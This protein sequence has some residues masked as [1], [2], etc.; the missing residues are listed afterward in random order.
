MHGALHPML[1]SWMPLSHP[2]PRCTFPCAPLPSRRPLSYFPPFPLYPTSLPS[3]CA[4]RADGAAVPSPSPHIFPRNEIIMR[5]PHPT[6]PMRDRR[7]EGRRRTLG[8]SERADARA[9]PPQGRNRRPSQAC[10]DTSNGLT[11]RCTVYLST[12]LS[13]CLSIHLSIHLF[14]HPSIHLSIYPSIHPSI[15]ISVP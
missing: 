1:C 8:R 2:H 15:Y 12:C 14:I 3:L 9:S 4:T 5:W 13:I 7:R 10:R 11:T 6:P